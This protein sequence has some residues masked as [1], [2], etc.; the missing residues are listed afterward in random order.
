MQRR[1]TPLFHGTVQNSPGLL[2]EHGEECAHTVT[3][4]IVIN[5]SI[6]RTNN[7]S[8]SGHN[9]RSRHQQINSSEAECFS[10]FLSCFSFTFFLT[11]QGKKI[12]VLV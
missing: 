8:Q 5:M 2:S 12:Q 9:L 3:N 4:W 6:I 7:T 10:V 1:P 11:I